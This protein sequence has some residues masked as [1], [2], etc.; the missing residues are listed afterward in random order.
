[1]IIVIIV[2][3]VLYATIGVMTAEANER[4]QMQHE[5]PFSRLALNIAGAILVGLW[6]LAWAARLFYKLVRWSGE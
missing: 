3:G 6:P 1:M 5:P 2:V 4:L